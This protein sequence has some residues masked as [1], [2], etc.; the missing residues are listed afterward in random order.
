VGDI[1]SVFLIE[2][3]QHLVLLESPF[4]FFVNGFAE[5]VKATAPYFIK[6]LIGY[7][8]FYYQLGWGL[9]MYIYLYRRYRAKKNWNNFYKNST[10]NWFLL[11]YSFLS[12]L[13]FSKAAWAFIKTYISVFYEIIY[14]VVNHVYLYTVLNNK[15]I[16]ALLKNKS[17]NIYS[18]WTPVFK[19]SSYIGILNTLKRFISRK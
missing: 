15:H 19:K 2:L 3:L 8:H 7:C 17:N 18:F 9:G 6:Y 10:L 13:I 1:L 16:R 4:S 11:K 12:K 14:L 5:F